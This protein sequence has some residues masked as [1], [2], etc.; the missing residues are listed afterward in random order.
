MS[1]FPCRAMARGGSPRRR[2]LRRSPAGRGKRDWGEAAS[3]TKQVVFL[4]AVAL[5][6]VGVEVGIIVL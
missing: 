4:W 5:L 1:F 6:L 2:V 3:S